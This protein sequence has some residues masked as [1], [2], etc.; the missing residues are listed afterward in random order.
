MGFRNVGPPGGQGRALAEPVAPSVDDFLAIYRPIKDWIAV[1]LVTHGH[2]DL[3]TI[4][5]QV[6]G[7]VDSD[8]A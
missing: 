7:T 6:F 8:D 5:R 3:Q 4:V 1:V 2:R